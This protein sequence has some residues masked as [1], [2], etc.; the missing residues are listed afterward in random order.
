MEELNLNKQFEQS[1]IW[2]NYNQEAIKG[3]VGYILDNI[4]EDVK[5]IIDI[6]CGNGIITNELAKKYKVTGAD[7]SREALTYIEGYS[8]RILSESLSVK[9]GQFDMIFS[10]ELLE[11]LPDRTL[12]AT[13]AEFK[14]VA[15][16]YIA[17]TVPNK[18]L[19]LKRFVKC[20]ECGYQFHVDH[21]VNSFSTE[22]LIELFKDDFRPV[23]TDY[24]GWNERV[25][26][27][28]L[29]NIKHNI[30]NVWWNRDRKYIIC[31]K[32]ENTSFPIDHDNSISKLCNATN[33]IVSF[34]KKIPYWMFI[35]F[36]RKNQD[37]S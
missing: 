19:L 15:R 9:T 23:K 10:S 31:P 26:N 28:W 8:I 21:H 36:Q 5:S 1:D 29:I 20:P 17:I 7:F 35:L 3:K 25:Y 4:P 12:Q 27:K 2:N 11:H 34:N 33:R 32:C 18:E 14:R 22:D 13:V 30:A 24:F 16:K 6:G 37:A